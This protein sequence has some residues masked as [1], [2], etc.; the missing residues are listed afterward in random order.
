[1]KRTKMPK[2]RNGSKGD[3]NPG[4]LDC[5]SGILPLSYRAPHWMCQLALVHWNFKAC[6]VSVVL[7]SC[8]IINNNNVFNSYRST[9][10]YIQCN[11]IYEK[12]RKFVQKRIQHGEW[13]NTTANCMLTDILS[14]MEN[15]PSQPPSQPIHIARLR[16]TMPGT[17]E[18]N[19]ATRPTM[20][21][22]H[23]R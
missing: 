3:S 11:L 9:P 12:K 14:R 2:L 23:N 10:R 8:V 21:A 6:I 13:Y 18:T 22:K 17:P 4:S 16:T 7:S 5:E 20:H 19:R 1:M 15:A